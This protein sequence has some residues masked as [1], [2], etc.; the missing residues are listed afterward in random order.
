[1]ENQVR[2]CLRGIP[3]AGYVEQ[4]THLAKAVGI[5][6]QLQFLPPAPPSEMVRLAAEHDLGLSL[7]LTHPHNRAICLTNKIFTYLLAGLPIVMSHTP[8]QTEFAQH[9]EEAAML[10][11]IDDPGAIA[12]V[13]DEFFCDPIK[14]QNARA[15]AWA[16]GR[17]RYNWEVEQKVFIHSVE[18]ALAAS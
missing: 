7:E 3:A 2:L 4:L 10:I 17:S 14:L 8:A 5:D 18:R 1:M 11:D 6:D 16:L 13:L 9:L 15:K 12:L